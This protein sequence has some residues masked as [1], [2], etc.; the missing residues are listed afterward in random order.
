[1]AS[2]ETAGVEKGLESPMKLAVVPSQEFDFIREILAKVSASNIAKYY[3][4]MAGAGFDSAESPAIDLARR[5]SS[6]VRQVHYG[7]VHTGPE[8]LA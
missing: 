7:P 1:M 3:K 5:V 6:P 4:V 8:G 2:E